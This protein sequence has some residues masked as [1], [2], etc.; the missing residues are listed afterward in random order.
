[1]LQAEVSLNMELAGGF[2]QICRLFMKVNL[3]FFLLGFMAA[4]FSAYLTENSFAYRD[5]LG[6]LNG[7]IGERVSLSSRSPDNSLRILLIENRTVHGRN[8]ELQLRS[9]GSFKNRTVFHS[10]DQERMS[11]SERILWD[12]KGEKFALIS[13]N[14]TL[15]ADDREPFKISTGE[16]LV[17]VYDVIKQT[18]YCPKSISRNLS[19]CSP[20]YIS[21]INN[22]KARNNL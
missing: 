17:F 15:G 5:G 22:F 3:V 11:G 9:N 18:A 14:F 21:T 16:T 13:R 10:T 20:L 6:N 1:V 12:D 2:L 19:Q 4:L 7:E 8:F